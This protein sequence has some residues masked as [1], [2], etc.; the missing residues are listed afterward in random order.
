VKSD[1]GRVRAGAASVLLCLGFV[2]VFARSVQ[3]MILSRDRILPLERMVNAR[4]T[5]PCVRPGDIFDRRDDPIATSVALSWVC[6]DP[7]LIADGDRPNV[8][9]VLAAQLGRR[10]E[11]IFAQLSRP[12]SH[13]VLAKGVRPQEARAVDRLGLKGIMVE[14]GYARLYPLG[15]IL[16]PV[17]GFREKSIRLTGLSGL[18]AALDPILIGAADRTSDA[19]GRLTPAVLT[20]GLPA[21]PREPC[22][23]VLTLDAR[24]Q[25]AAFRIMSKHMADAG[26]EA[27]S[28]TIMDPVTG[29]ILSM[30]SLPSFDPNT[31]ERVPKS[32]WRRFQT[33]PAS[34]AFEPGSMCKP[35]ILAAALESGAVTVDQ[36]FVCAGTRRLSGWTIGCWG[37]Y[38][39]A[40]HGTVTP[41]TALIHSC[42]LTYAQISTATGA[43]QLH[44]W[45]Q[46]LGLGR[47]TGSECHAEASGSLP[48]VDRIGSVKLA[49]MGYGQ[50]LT[51]TGLQV[52]AAVGA[53]ANRGVLM[54]PH[55]VS[56]LVTPGG[57]VRQRVE[58][59]VVRQ[60]ISERTAEIVLEAMERVV[61]EGTGR[62]ARIPGCRV[63]GKTGT[64]QKVGEGA[65]AGG[66]LEKRYVSTFVGV[67]GVGTKRPIVALVWFDEP[68]GGATGGQVGAPAFKQVAEAALR[69]LG[70]LPAASLAAGRRAAA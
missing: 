57:E 65:E 46:E 21:G 16:G 18:E 63:C 27:A 20:A 5:G 52:V 55:I 2:L 44:G 30:V 56:A 62:S 64:A 66:Y 11:G 40:G 67:A 34:V 29:E 58:P 14:R 4:R 33:S 22:N 24:I 28:C 37:R 25:A 61:Q 48:P 7:S 42:N 59:H 43:S 17:V 32:E 39:S 12:L 60:A 68:A 51:V 69:H 35:L 38:R 54:R 31:F 23:V 49:T 19:E 9:R 36:R 26:A 41:V 70:V 47:S 6:A 8:A 15:E 1:I 10:Q 45:L 53:I 13:V 3:I 50:S